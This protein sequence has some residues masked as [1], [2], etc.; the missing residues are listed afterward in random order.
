MYILLNNH[1]IIPYGY[2]T[3][4]EHSSYCKCNKC[5]KA[6]YDKRS[7]KGS[8]VSITLDR[9]FFTRQIGG[10]KLSLFNIDKSIKTV[11]KVIN[12]KTGKELKET[13]YEFRPGQLT[14]YRDM[15]SVTCLCWVMDM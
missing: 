5:S 11:K 14:V 12:H 7:N 8:D 15:E 1:K 9:D 10:A 13:L 2:H 3:V 6:S 4:S